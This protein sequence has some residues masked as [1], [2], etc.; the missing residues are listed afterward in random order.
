[1]SR[2]SAKLKPLCAA[3][4]I[5]LAA[6]ALSVAGENADAASPPESP[7]DAT[8][9]KQV[10]EK[11]EVN[12]S[13]AN[14]NTDSTTIGKTPTAVKDL[15]QTVNIVNRELLEAQGAT[16]FADA[17]RNVPGITIGGAEGG[18]IGNNINLRG[19]TARTDVYIDGFRDRGQYYRDTFDL[20][21]I[22]VL[23]GPSSMLFGR[24]STGG[25]INQVSKQAQLRDFGEVTA[26]LGSDGRARTSADLNHPF[27]G[28]LRGPRQRVRCRI[29]RRRRA[30]SCRT[31]TAASRRRCAS[32]SAGRPRSRCRRCSST[33]TTCP[34]TA[35]RRSTASPRRSIS[36]I[37]TASPTTARTRPWI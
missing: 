21:S 7:N 11:V 4:L 34:T 32:A 36:T 3:L 26:T 19:F 22:E 16:S 29:M 15:P 28:R 12:A 27:L 20:D 31:R 30:T 37:S 8:D 5:A 33:I 25:V 13:T 23:K 6:P 2:R 1:M 18:Q 9:N 35:C 14:Y 17:L 24:G 10:L